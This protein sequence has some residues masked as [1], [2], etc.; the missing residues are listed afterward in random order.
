MRYS[1]RENEQS[2]N[3][4]RW[5]SLDRQIPDE[6]IAQITQPSQDVTESHEAVVA[7]RNE[8]LKLQNRVSALRI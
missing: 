4:R 6:I 5:P 8:V 3:C 7:R 1:A 2:H